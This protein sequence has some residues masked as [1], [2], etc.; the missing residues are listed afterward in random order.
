MP[1]RHISAVLPKKEKEKDGKTV[2]SIWSRTAQMPKREIL[3][4]NITVDAAVIGG[5]M[6]GVLTAYQLR[7]RGMDAVVLEAEKTGSGQTKNTTAKITGQH[8]LIYDRLIRQF[9]GERA[10]QYAKIN[11]DAIEEYERIIGAEKIDCDFRRLPACLYSARD[12]EALRQERDA[13]KCLGIPAE[14]TAITELPFPGVCALAFPEQAQFHPLRFLRAVAEKVPVFE[15]TEAKRVLPDKVETSR[16]NVAAKHIVF[17]THYPF[18]NFPG[19]YFARIHQERSYVL[20]LSGPPS[21][22]AMYY[23]VDPDGLSFR[24][25]GDLLL[26]GGSGHRTGESGASGGYEELR[27][28][29]RRLWPQCRETVAWSAQDCKTLDG[30]PYVGRFSPSRPAWYVATGFNKWGMTGSMAAALLL[31]EQIAK[32]D[33]EDADVFSPR[34]FVLRAS[35]PNL[36]KEIGKSAKGLLKEILYF[37]GREFD[38]LAPGQG[39]VIRWCGK[40]RGAYRDPSGAVYLV[41]TRCPHLGCQLEWNPHERSWDCPCHGSRFDV[42]GNL[43]DNP[44]QC[45]LKD[46]QKA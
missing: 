43:I 12:P 33:R 28:K 31:S 8:G 11:Q 15:H 3:P 21:L 17:A 9:G 24:G 44:A 37:P 36:G 1:F 20:A 42:R 38:R 29:A 23:G 27:R 19:L 16:G 6:A 10:R 30:V 34:R 26:L 35:L 41:S 13:A 32:A 14:L 18:V 39:A 2:E 45:G 25:A 4:G 46:T 7:R 5:G 22:S 40:K